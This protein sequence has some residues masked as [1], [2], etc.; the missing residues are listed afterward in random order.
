VA[1]P[2]AATGPAI[3]P[4]PEPTAPV[5]IRPVAQ[6]NPAHELQRMLDRHF[7]PRAALPDPGH[8]RLVAILEPLIAQASRAAGIGLFVAALVAIAAMIW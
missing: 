5:S 4:E 2:I 7:G 3:D 6:G 8:S 1:E